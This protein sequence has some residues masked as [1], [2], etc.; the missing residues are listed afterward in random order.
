MFVKIQRLVLDISKSNSSVQDILSQFI[1]YSCYSALSYC[2]PWSE[3]LSVPFS[4]LFLENRYLLC[5]TYRLNRGF[6]SSPRN[7]WPSKKSIAICTHK[8]HILKHYLNKKLI[9]SLLISCYCLWSSIK[10]A[11]SMTLY[12]N[13]SIC[14]TAN[15][16]WGWGGYSIPTAGLWMM[17]LAYCCCTYFF[18]ITTKIQFFTQQGSFFS[19]FFSPFSI[20][21]FSILQP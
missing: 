14:T 6:N 11:S 9:T 1:Y 12:W 21:V 5:V 13:P 7:K 18:F 16:F 2:C 10:I 20:K 15:C 8:R 17:N 19:H 4:S 3:T